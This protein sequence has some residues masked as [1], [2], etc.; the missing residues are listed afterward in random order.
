MTNL[1]LHHRPLPPGARA[2]FLDRDGVINVDTGY[3]CDPQTVALV[4]GAAQ[5]IAA[6]NA[7]KL[8]AIVVTNQS[9]LSRGLADLATL[10][11]VQMQ[12]EAL[13]HAEAGA[14]LDAVFICCASS[15]GQGACE[16]AWRKPAPGMFLAAR[17]LLGVDLA[18]STII[19]DKPSDIEAAAAAGLHSGILLESRYGADPNISRE[20]M[21]KR[22]RDMFE[23]LEIL[24]RHN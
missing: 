24:S 8:P 20:F 19:G 6:A 9:A 23:V 3:V 17:R 18:N 13:L 22:A 4:P 12:V 5:L 16:G 14:C 21:L 10:I 7:R 1:F 11:A 15:D 2:L